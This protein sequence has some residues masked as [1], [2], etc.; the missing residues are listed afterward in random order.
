[1]E[2]LTHVVQYIILYLIA[3]EQQVYSD[4]RGEI[5][6]KKLCKVNVDKLTFEFNP[7]TYLFPASSVWLRMAKLKLTWWGLYKQFHVVY[8][9]L[10]AS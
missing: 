1:M 3:D 7:Q 2:T 5:L 4:M 8:K 6:L 10:P 9:T